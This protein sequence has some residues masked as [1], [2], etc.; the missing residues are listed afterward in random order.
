MGFSRQ[1]YWSGVPCPPLGIFPTQGS[2]QHLLHLLHGRGQAG[3]SP[4]EPPAKPHQLY[5]NTK[6]KGKNSVLLNK[7]AHMDG[8]ILLITYLP[9]QVL[10]QGLSKRRWVTRLLDERTNAHT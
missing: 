8:C 3:S 5:A 1:E 2:H 4:L 10:A 7:D 6:Q 9:V